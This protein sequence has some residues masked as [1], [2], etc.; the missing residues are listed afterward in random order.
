MIREPS[1]VGDKMLVR[2][3]PISTSGLFVNYRVPTELV[4]AEFNS[5]SA[6]PDSLAS[7]SANKTIIFSDEIIEEVLY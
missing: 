6:K 3:A 4:P 5:V 7:I 1:K 2:Q